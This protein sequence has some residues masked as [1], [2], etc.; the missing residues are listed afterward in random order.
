MPRFS[1]KRVLSDGGERILQEMKAGARLVTRYA[2]LDNLGPHVLLRDGTPLKA[3]S[4]PH[5]RE[6]LGAARIV[7]TEPCEAAYIR[8]Y[9]LAERRTVQSAVAVRQSERPPSR[10]ANLRTSKKPRGEN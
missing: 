4:E 6:L 1:V 8:C 7:I 5:I 10:T 2:P 3:V 9:A